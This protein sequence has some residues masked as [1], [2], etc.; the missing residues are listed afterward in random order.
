M[1]AS[2]FEELDA[3]KLADELKKKVYALL[4]RTNARKDR[5]FC[6]QLT[7][8]A[9][10]APANL[11]E[12]FGYYRHPEFAKHTRIAKSSMMETQNHLR[13]GVDR[14][15]W[16]AQQADPLLH[17]ADRAIGACVR[18]ITYLEASEAPRAR[19]RNN[20][21]PG[22]VYPRRE[23]PTRQHPAPSTY[24]FAVHRFFAPAMDPGDESVDLPRAEAEHLTRVLRLGVGDTVAV[25]DG[26]GREF[27]AKV[28]LA[29]K[30]QVRVQLLSRLEPA[31]EPVVAITLAQAVLKADKMDDVVRD[32]VMLGV[33]AIQP[34]VTRRTE[35]TVAAL[36]RG[37]RV[38][39]WQR[40]A[41]ASVKQ[42][43]RAVLPEVRMP[44]TL[45][46]YLGDPPAALRLMLVEPAAAGNADTP[47][48]HGQGGDASEAT[49]AGEEAEPVRTLSF[50]QG[51]PPPHDAVVLV[52]PEGGW[53]RDECAAAERNGVQLVTLGHR[54]LRADAVPIAAIS[55]LQFVWGEL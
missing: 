53:T 27:L 1:A 30:R 50:L 39:R 40:V 16:S 43:R 14:R 11:A 54:T 25:F 31:S 35:T 5:R 21:K 33:T 20:T 26:R 13:D 49:E 24:N 6:D 55:V 22:T 45:E 4:D 34:I 8:A 47:R 28:A 19:R 44:L 38:E 46:T 2:R 18:L 41:L 15:F 12:R 48:G 9:A 32:A 37:A 23:Q 10:S 42:S 29:A 51:Q 7:A 3:W 17:I 36:M 52:G